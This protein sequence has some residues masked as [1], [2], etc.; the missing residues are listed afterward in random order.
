M[1]FTYFAR[2]L[3]KLAALLACIMLVLA[4]LS[5]IEFTF[6]SKATAASLSVV[7]RNALIALRVVFA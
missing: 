7:L 5:N 2:L 6:G 1:L 4:N 3:F